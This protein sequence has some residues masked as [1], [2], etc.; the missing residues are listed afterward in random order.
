M[1]L[2]VT[3]QQQQKPFAFVD[4][5][6]TMV[7]NMSARNRRVTNRVHEKQTPLDTSA[8]SF[9]SLGRATPTVATP[10]SWRKMA[11]SHPR[12]PTPTQPPSWSEIAAS[13]P[14]VPT[15]P[16]PTKC[17]APAE[18]KF[19]RRLPSSTPLRSL[20]EE[21]DQADDACST[22]SDPYEDVVDNIHDM[23]PDEEKKVYSNWGDY[24][25]DN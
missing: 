9:P 13:I 4:A 18:V 7:L 10:P 25:M 15:P 22:S 17:E 5:D 20:S 3:T 6:N 16:A 12:V 19:A 14:R 1:P 8:S 11:A 24:P 21:L 2:S 23:M